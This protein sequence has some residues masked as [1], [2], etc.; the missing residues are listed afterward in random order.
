MTMIDQF[1]STGRLFLAKQAM[2]LIQL[3]SSKQLL[4][5]DVE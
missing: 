5:M 2:E 3:V 4:L 1:S